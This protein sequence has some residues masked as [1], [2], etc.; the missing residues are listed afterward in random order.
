MTLAENHSF[1]KVKMPSITER[2]ISR[3]IDARMI[4]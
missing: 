1:G 2:E 3:V 4:A